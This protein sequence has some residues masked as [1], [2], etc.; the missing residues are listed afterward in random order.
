MAI[1]KPKY[2]ISMSSPTSLS[3]PFSLAYQIEEGFM[4]V[5]PR[6]SDLD[7][8]GGESGGGQDKAQQ[9][10]ETTTEQLSEAHT[11]LL[12]LVKVGKRRFP[13]PEKPPSG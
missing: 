8:L 12:N 6:G 9:H 7:G 1:P 5:H 4:F 13:L 11:F 3:Q 2:K 10:G